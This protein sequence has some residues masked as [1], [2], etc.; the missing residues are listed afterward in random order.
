[1]TE[2]RAKDVDATVLWNGKRVTTAWLADK[3]HQ[4]IT[5]Q[6]AND[7]MRVRGKELLFTEILILK[8]S[9]RA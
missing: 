5:V 2:P 3:T 7:S 1:M 6:R 8:N 4:A 9:K